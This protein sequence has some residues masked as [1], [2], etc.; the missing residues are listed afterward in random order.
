[1]EAGPYP[2]QPPFR[3]WQ[4]AWAWGPVSPPDFRFMVGLLLGLALWNPVVDLARWARKLVSVVPP[5]F[6]SVVGFLLG[7]ALGAPVVVLDRLAV[8]RN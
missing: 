7:L 6:R 8:S 4:V 1:M 3:R 5:E 2:G